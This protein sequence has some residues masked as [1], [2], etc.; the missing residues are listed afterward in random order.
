MK[1]STQS[2]SLAALAFVLL[3][4]CASHREYF[5][6]SNPE[7]PYSSAVRV[8]NTVYISGHLGVDSTTNQ[9][10][11]NIEDEIRI[12]LNRFAETLAR[13]GL[14][15]DHM[16]QMQV[17]CSDVALYKT[18]N[19]LYRER[20]KKNFPARAFIGSGKLLRGCHFEI[21]GIAAD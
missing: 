12:M 10:P 17:H 2:L 19:D 9:A 13:T 18:F 6:G 21:I 15:M 4:S 20:F 11:A 3:S 16:V 14:T 1:N 7:L 5:P 8:G